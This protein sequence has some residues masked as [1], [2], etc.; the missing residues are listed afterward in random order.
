MITK[1]PFYGGTVATLVL[2][3][4]V[5]CNDTTVPTGES[6]AQLASEGRGGAFTFT[7]LPASAVCTVPGG[8]PVHPLLLPPGF[9]QEILASEPSFA[10]LPDMNTQNETSMTT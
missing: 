6:G 10:D 2:L 3:A 5:G 7:P 9:A 8:D 4:A 1:L